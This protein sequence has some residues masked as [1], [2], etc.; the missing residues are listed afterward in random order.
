MHGSG[1]GF[2]D[3]GLRRYSLSKGEGVDLHDQ[4]EKRIH[5]FWCQNG[6]ADLS[7]WELSYWI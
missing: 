5:L 3:L 6:R 1:S 2:L 7:L 4:R